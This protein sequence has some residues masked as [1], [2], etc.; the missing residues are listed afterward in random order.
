MK[1]SMRHE[2]P[3]VQH[4]QKEAPV[5]VLRNGDKAVPLLSLTWESVAFFPETLHAAFFS[6]F[7]FTSG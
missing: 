6:I 7:F 4:F 5:S 3:F 1:F 2:F